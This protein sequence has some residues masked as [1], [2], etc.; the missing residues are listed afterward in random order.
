MSSVRLVVGACLP[1][2]VGAKLLELW[3]PAEMGAELLELLLAVVLLTRA[4]RVYYAISMKP[5]LSSS[6]SRRAAYERPTCS[7]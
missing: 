3:L 2:A 4:Y 5:S 6:A 1:A 7:Y